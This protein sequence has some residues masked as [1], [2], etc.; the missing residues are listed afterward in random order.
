MSVINQALKDL[1]K[2]EAQ[3]VTKNFLPLPTWRSKK[4]NKSAW[5]V[6][7][8]SV[9]AF[10]IFIIDCYIIF[11]N[12]HEN[13]IT[14]KEISSPANLII[15]TDEHIKN[16]GLLSSSINA[17]AVFHPRADIALPLALITGVTLQTQEDETVLRLFSSEKILYRLAF[18]VAEENIL[19]TLEH[20]LP[21]ANLPSIDYPSSALKNA[22]IKPEK[23]GHVLL[24]FSLKKGAELIAANWVETAKKPVFEMRFHY[25]ADLPTIVNKK[26]VVI[27]V[28]QQ[29]LNTAKMLI[30]NNRLADALA[31]L[32]EFSPPINEHAD[33][34]ALM[35]A[36]YQ[37]TNQPQMAV[38]LY[39]TLITQNPRNPILWM[40]LA[41]S[42]ESA[43]KHKGALSAYSH[44]E[45]SD[46]L[47]P[48]LKAWIETK[49]H[50]L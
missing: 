48:V 49:L 14:K 9:F 39:K 27:P 13:K 6:V 25:H 41:V 7:M 34:Y 19:L 38:N 1:D 8:L 47:S 50:P 28:Y 22:M 4:N 20:A 24:K 12:W 10:F 37:R 42:L 16:N 44:A 3:K 36:L 31:L 5:L 2:R 18:D 40:G 46:K 33:Y 23:N 21:F 32:E 29:T 11:Q 17:P 35:A 26:P 30:K 45:E 43:G 15:H